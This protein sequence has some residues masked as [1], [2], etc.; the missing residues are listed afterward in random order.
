MKRVIALMLVLALAVPAQAWH[1]F[2]VREKIVTV[3]ETNWTVTI[4]GITFVAL[5]ISFFAVV[6]SKEFIN[7]ERQIQRKKN[8]KECEDAVNYKFNAAGLHL[9]IFPDDT[10]K[11]YL[12]SYCFQ[13]HM[14]YFINKNCLK[15]MAEKADEFSRENVNP[16][17]LAQN[18][19]ETSILE[20]TGKH[21]RK[22]LELLMYE[23]MLRDQEALKD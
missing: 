19:L 5:I 17:D 8:I 3:K 23:D 22:T 20:Q 4:T 7:R 6:S 21:V 15:A 1:L 11:I 18:R 14:S 13:Y 2:P 16:N 9:S 12:S 10:D